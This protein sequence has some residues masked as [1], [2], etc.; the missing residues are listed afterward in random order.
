MSSDWS[1]KDIPAQVKNWLTKM[2]SQDALWQESTDQ[3]FKDLENPEISYEVSEYLRRNISVEDVNVMLPF[4]DNLKAIPEILASGKWNNGRVTIQMSPSS[5]SDQKW[6]RMLLF[7]GKIKTKGALVSYLTLDFAM[8][9]RLRKGRPHGIIRRYGRLVTDP[10]HVC[11][12]KLFKGLSFIGR[13]QDGQAV[14]FAW[15]IVIGG[16]FI[17]GRVDGMGQ[18]TGDDIAYVYPDVKTAL[19][20]K[21]KNGIM[22]EAKEAKVVGT[23][24]SSGMMELK[25]SEPQDPLFTHSTIPNNL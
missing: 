22:V 5:A 23:R 21:F 9:A 8:L 4:N 3:P 19:V 14:G 1:T 12:N 18:L 7:N 24:S 13:Y 25:F 11:H 10:R 16:G 15:R 17:Y 20:G 2:E 6:R